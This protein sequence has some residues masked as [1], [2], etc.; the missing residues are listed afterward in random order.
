MRK[1]SSGHHDERLFAGNS[2]DVGKILKIGALLVPAFLGLSISAYC[3]LLSRL[4]IKLNLSSDLVADAQITNYIWIRPLLLSLPF[5][6]FCLI[7]VDR[8]GEKFLNTKT[9]KPAIKDSATANRIAYIEL[10]LLAF[11]ALIYSFTMNCFWMF[12]VA[13]IAIWCPVTIHLTTK[14]V[15]PLIYNQI[16][17]VLPVVIVYACAEGWMAGDSF[18]TGSRIRYKCDVLSEGGVVERRQVIDIIQRKN[19]AIVLNAEH[20]LELIQCN[21]IVKTVFCNE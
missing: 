7:L 3:G 4:G 6:L 21:R 8:Y 12:C 20:C 13:V 5:A 1:K 10:P 17:G 16:A 15:L 11:S 9:K 2:D 18:L 19:E 14:R